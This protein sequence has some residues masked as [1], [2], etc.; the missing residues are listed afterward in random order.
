MVNNSIDA[1]WS[2]MVPPLMNIT[3]S[4]TEGAEWALSVHPEQ[5]EIREDKTK[6][7]VATFPLIILSTPF[8]QVNGFYRL[9][10]GLIFGKTACIIKASS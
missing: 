5:R 10:N 8:V 9:Y 2:S 3:G 6:N 1:T 4:F 7:M